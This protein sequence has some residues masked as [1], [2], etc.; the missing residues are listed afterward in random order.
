[1]TR[2]TAALAAGTESP[3]CMVSANSVAILEL[4]ARS[5]LSSAGENL[6]SLPTADKSANAIGHLHLV[7]N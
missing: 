6:Y 1:M 5:S 2:R 3:D 4:S 7:H